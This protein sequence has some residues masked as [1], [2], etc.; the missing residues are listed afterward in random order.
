V[1]QNTQTIVAGSA[2]DLPI[3]AWLRGGATKAVFGTGDA[4]VASVL[5]RNVAAP[6]FQ[7]SVAWYTANS[8]QNGYGQGQVMV[9]GTNA[10]SALLTPGGAYTLV[11]DWTPSGGSITEPIVRNQLIVEPRAI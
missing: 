6:I 5:Q 7:P 11:V 8:T 3:Q 2:F 4:I 10:Q 9:S 1:N